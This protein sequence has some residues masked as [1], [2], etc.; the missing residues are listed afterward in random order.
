MGLVPMASAFALQCSAN[1]AMKSH[2]LG[3]NQR[4]EF[5]FTYD[6]NLTWNEVDS[7]C[8]NIDEMEML[9]SRLISVTGND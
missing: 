4:I 6:R 5:I 9:I 1:W 3:G 8:G 2:M 7:K